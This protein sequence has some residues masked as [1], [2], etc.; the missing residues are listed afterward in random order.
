[1]VSLPL[2]RATTVWVA[3]LAGAI[4]FGSLIGAMFIGQQFVQNVLGYDTLTA[5]AVV[6]PS[7]ICAALFGQV[8]GQLIIKRGSRPTLSLGLI[9]VAIAFAIMLLTWHEGTSIGW[10]LVAYGFVGTGVG[11]SATPASRALMS[12]MPQSHAGLGSALLDLTR[13]F[14]GAVLQAVLGGML[15]AA[16]A[17]QMTADISGLPAEQAAQVTD[18]IA[19]ELTSSFA[20]AAEIASHYAPPTSQE[21]INA[22]SV[23]FTDGKSAAICV[24]L[25]LSLIGLLIVWLRFPSKQVEEA[26]YA[27]VAQEV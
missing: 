20:G 7:A 10:V 16:Y 11:L 17:K 25:A 1:L 23:A 12:S 6:L 15:A 3:F 4:T 21:I 2:A 5:A 18:Q 9:C 14:G 27:K 22:A 19:D 13:D 24:A 8:A 26:Y